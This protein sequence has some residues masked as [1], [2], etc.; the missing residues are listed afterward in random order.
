MK[1]F[2]V[3]WAEQ[4]AIAQ[5]KMRLHLMNYRYHVASWIKNNSDNSDIVLK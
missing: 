5:V 3:W 1:D 2:E 4:A